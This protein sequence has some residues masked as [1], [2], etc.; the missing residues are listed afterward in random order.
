MRRGLSAGYTLIE[1]VVVVAI[2][3]ILAAILLPV[4]ER[5]TKSAESISC[6]M[7]LRNIGW[8]AQIY[9][10]D[11]DGYFPPALIDTENQSVQNCWDILLQPYL[12]SSGVY[13]CPADENPTPGPSYTNSLPHSYGVNLDVT[14]VG[15]YAGASYKQ[16]HI[17]QPCGIILFF[18][19]GQA[20]SYGWRA[21]WG[22]MSQYVAARHNQ[23]SNFVFCEGNAKRIRPPQTLTDSVNCWEP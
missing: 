4:F 16:I 21:S 17:D 3:M 7:N 5:A 1:L 13:I 10:G 12:G 15:G 6:L 14:M 18:D 9:A 2:I 8:A 22:N 11:Y 20:Y 23:S 19:L